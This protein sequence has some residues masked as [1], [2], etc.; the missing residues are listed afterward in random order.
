MADEERILNLENDALLDKF[1]DDP[2][3]V[4][5]GLANE[6]RADLRSEIDREIAESRVVGTYE[7]FKS[8]HPRFEEKWKSGEIKAYIAA[9]PGHNALSGYLELTRDERMQEAVSKELAKKGLSGNDD[10][11]KD[12]RKHGGTNTVLA[13]RLHGRRAGG[14]GDNSPPKSPGEL[15]PTV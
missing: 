1:S 11:L 3:G 4:L 8:Q 10:R 9:H 15:I 6:I 2:K 5:T 14:S 13:Q 7:K 12:S